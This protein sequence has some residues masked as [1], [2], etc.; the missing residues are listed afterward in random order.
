VNRHQVLLGDDDFIAEHQQLQ[1]SEL[2]AETVRIERAAVAL[3]LTEYR[4]RLPDSAEAMARILIHRVH[5][6]Q[7]RSRF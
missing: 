4:R 1:R 2:L 3:S 7:H 5:D 6:A